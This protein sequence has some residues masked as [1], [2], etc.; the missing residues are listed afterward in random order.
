MLPEPVEDEQVLIPESTTTDQKSALKINPVSQKITGSFWK[1][2]GNILYDVFPNF[3]YA[4]GFYL[5]STIGLV[6][7]SRSAS[8]I[9]IDGY[10]IG[11]TW[12]TIVCTAVISSLCQGTITLCSQAFGAGNFTT[13][14]LC[15]HRGFFLRLIFLIIEIPLL[16]FSYYI[17]KAF[18]VDEDIAVQA[19]LY[20]KYAVIT[21]IPLI[22]VEVIRT[23]YVSTHNY[24]PLMFF[25]FLCV[26]LNYILCRYFVIDLGLEIGGVVLAY[27]ITL[28]A[29]VT[30]MVLHLWIW[31]SKSDGLFYP[32]KESCQKLFP[33]LKIEIIIATFFYLEQIAWQIL[34]L[35]GAN[36][37][38]TQVNVQVVISNIVSIVMMPMFGLNIVA[39]TYAGA[40]IGQKNIPAIKRCV[41]Y[42]A[43]IAFIY[44]LF[45]DA[46]I[47]I[48]RKEILRIYSTD[49][50]IISAGLELVKVVVFILPMDFVRS[51]VVSSL[52][53]IGR[54]KIG[55]LAFIFSYYVVGLIFEFTL[56]TVAGWYD[57][58]LWIGVGIGIG[59]MLALVTVLMVRTDYAKAVEMIQQRIIKLD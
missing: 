58:G 32:K 37:S 36:Y 54:E 4:L 13:L 38:A 50:A 5:Y 40:Y 33:Q 3:I 59:T 15:L 20:C 31:H 6:L 22:L 24:I 2:T 34:T 45:I 25:Q 7:L 8:T 39:T 19:S 9:V 41:V 29:L 26:P 30:M 53:S 48:W 1:D 14:G 42:S 35:L 23:Y 10:G 11:C 55:S 27:S 44:A 28:V 12:Y 21:L 57:L 17:F 49:D 47:L 16:A 18:Q 43:M 51:T 52:K 56:G 46:C